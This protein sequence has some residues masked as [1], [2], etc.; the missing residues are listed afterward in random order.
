LRLGY[1]VKGRREVKKG[2]EAGLKEETSWLGQG[3]KD[4]R[5]AAEIQNVLGARVILWFS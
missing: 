4:G 5:L 3:I 2:V 1:L